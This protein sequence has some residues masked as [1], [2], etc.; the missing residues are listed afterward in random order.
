MKIGSLVV[1]DGYPDD[2]GIVLK[3]GQHLHHHAISMCKI[4]WSCGQLTWEMQD[5]LEVIA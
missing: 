3:L 1:I 4:R 5:D 2:V